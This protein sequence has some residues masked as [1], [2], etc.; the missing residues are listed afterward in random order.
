MQWAKQQPHHSADSSEALFDDTFA[1]QAHS[2]E[3]IDLP[4]AAS[5]EPAATSSPR[6]KSQQ[7][8]AQSSS[9]TTQASSAT[10]SSS[11]QVKQESVSSSSMDVDQPS[12]QSSSKS[13]NSSALS[14]SDLTA[15]T[16]Q[17]TSNRAQNTQCD[18]D[19]G[20]D[21]TISRIHATISYDAELC[22]WDI[23]CHSSNGLLV[24]GR[25]IY[26]RD[27]PAL[28]PSKSRIQIGSV[29]FFFLLPLNTPTKAD[30]A[31]PL[32]PTVTLSSDLAQFIV[33][34]EAYEKSAGA[35][36]SQSASA[37]SKK[38]KRNDRTIV[39][40][41]ALELLSE[42]SKAKR[43]CFS[44]SAS[45]RSNSMRSLLFGNGNDEEMEEEGWR[46][47]LE[48]PKPQ[49]AL[50]SA[51]LSA[52]FDPPLEEYRESD[53][54]S[55]YSQQAVESLSRAAKVAAVAD[56]SM[57]DSKVG[58]RGPRS[59]KPSE[60]T[61]ASGVVY[62]RP[63]LTYG[64]LIHLALESSP[65]KR[66]LFPE[67]ADYIEKTFPYFST[68]AAGNWHN[69]VR[70]QLSHTSDFVRQERTQTTGKGKGKGGYW[71]LAHWYDGDR[72]LSRPK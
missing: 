30:N 11:S 19:L 63:K 62:E 51:H 43:K 64:Q 44:E 17:S 6:Q 10:P 41:R 4:S 57:G 67:I 46:R 49:E 29:L 1:S 71:A 33:D 53:R 7:E 42:S 27:G 52:N 39:P 59:N 28:L 69:T 45:K 5:L 35:K 16:S 68:N 37:V 34:A 66:M 14:S 32:P 25:N 55:K 21:P 65:E 9:A 12:A 3:N 23:S 58:S 50:T 56:V 20:H 24:N 26:P 38:R 36:A 72:L 15:A 60:G 8:I 2:L 22:L 47:F 18:I 31:K 54:L 40:L 61:D 13:A 48:R 70:Q